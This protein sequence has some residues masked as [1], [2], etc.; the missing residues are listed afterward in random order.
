MKTE[1][2]NLFSGIRT[3]SGNVCVCVCV[4]GNEDENE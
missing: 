3:T 1:I 2:E 4:L